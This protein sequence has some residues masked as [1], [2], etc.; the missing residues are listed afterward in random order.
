[1]ALKANGEGVRPAP[2][3]SNNRP[4]P[5]HSR[6]SC[7]A[8]KK[9][10]SRCLMDSPTGVPTRK[11]QIQPRWTLGRRSL[12]ID[13]QRLDPL[14]SSPYPLLNAEEIRRD[15]IAK[16]VRERRDSRLPPKALNRG[17]SR[18]DSRSGSFFIHSKSLHPFA[19]PCLS[20]DDLSRPAYMKESKRS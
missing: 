12:T 9:S 2:H 17:S 10:L 20:N 19:T 1:M 3:T 15:L 6:I 18:M 7:N 14:V 13:I 5:K 11:R 16:W 4:S 8:F